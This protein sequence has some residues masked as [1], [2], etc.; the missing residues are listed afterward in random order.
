IPQRYTG[1]AELAVTWHPEIDEHIR[2]V[3]AAALQHIAQT[4]WRGVRIRQDRISPSAEKWT[5]NI[6]YPSDPDNAA[7]AR[8]A[9]M[10]SLLQAGSERTDLAHFTPV[11]PDA[12]LVDYP[13]PVTPGRAAS[14]RF[15]R[16]LL[17]TVM[18]PEG[19]API[20]ALLQPEGGHPTAAL[21]RLRR[22]VKFRRTAE[23]DQIHI[24]YESGNPTMLEPVLRAIA[25]QM[26]ETAAQKARRARQ[27]TA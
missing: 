13:G 4:M 20:V 9:I 22:D 17:Q 23:G 25:A 11:S 14:L 12:L 19:A 21:L 3:K 2:Q 8:S 18:S 26:I 6:D 16:D 24:T 7:A 1:H 10:A 15:W 27:E 5:V